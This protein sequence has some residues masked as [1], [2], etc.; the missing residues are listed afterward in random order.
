MADNINI[1]FGEIA[2][3]LKSL[4]ND[5]I[6]G[7]ADDIYD[8]SLG[9][10][11]SEINNS[12]GKVTSIDNH[13]KGTL[14]AKSSGL[15]KVAIDAAGH[16]TG[17][18]AVAKADI[19]GLGIPGTDTQMTSVAATDVN[20]CNGDKLLKYFT[21]S[22]S[23][24]DSEGRRFAGTANNYGFPVTSNANGLM[25]LGNHTG[26]Y[27]HQLGFSSNGKIYHRKIDNGVFP[28][29]ENGGSWKQLAFTSDIPAA[30]SHPTNGANTSVG[31]SANASPTH[32]GTFTV[33]YITVNNLGHVTAASNKTITLPNTSYE[34]YL[35]W[36][37]RSLAASLSPVDV[38]TDGQWSANRLSFMPATGIQVE[39]STNG[40]TSWTDYGLTDA[41]KQSLVTTGLSQTLYMGNNGTSQT[42]NDMLRVTITA[43]SGKTYF[44]LK[45]IYAYLCT[46]GA[47]STMVK[48]EKAMNGSDTTFVEVGEYPVSG[49]SG[50]N[51]IP[52]AVSFGGGDNQTGNVRRIRMTFYFTAYGNNYGPDATN[53]VKFYVTNIQMMGETSWSNSGGNLA[54]TGHMYSWDVNKTVTFPAT[55]KATSIY[56]NGTALSSKYYHSGNTAA[57]NTVL[58]APASASGNISF[59]KLVVADMPN[60]LKAN[61]DNRS[62]NQTPAD[63]NG[64]FQISGLKNN[65]TIGLDATTYGTYSHVWGMKSWSG[66]SGGQAHEFANTQKGILMHR[67]GKSETEWNAWTQ[68]IEGETSTT[69]DIQDLFK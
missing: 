10:Y 32:G 7:V 37:G 61:T 26:N 21:L 58:A 60:G 34:A 6:L 42:V 52:L 44:S 19:T 59:R 3:A 43:E 28:T 14:G 62:V 15:Y 20:S 69:A 11:Q 41:Q 66:E 36:G 9:K 27:G 51:S 67:Y 64:V 38:A 5:H 25:W 56:E 1:S 18:T 65:S 4:A 24:A 23:T 63:Y 57:A 29:T 16:V 50:W 12:S 48:I 30:Y 40:G 2:N 47:S 33:P 31:P 54:K 13:Y 45:K 53:K 46:N 17:A 68:I 49:W 22:G 8:E 35:S 39:Y 55:L